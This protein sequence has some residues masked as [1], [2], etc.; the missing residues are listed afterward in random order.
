MAAAIKW[1]IGPSDN[2][3][4]P[5]RSVRTVSFTPAGPP[6]PPGCYF[7]TPPRVP[8]ARACYL[9]HLQASQ[10]Y[11]YT[12]RTDLAKE[13]G[14]PGAPVIEARV[15]QHIEIVNEQQ[16]VK[17]MGNFP[18]LLTSSLS[19]MT[20]TGLAGFEGMLVPSRVTIVRQS[21]G[22]I[23]VDNPDREQACA[24]G[25]VP[26]KKL[27]NR[28]CGRRVLPRVAVV[29]GYDGPGR[30]KT[31]IDGTMS[32]YRHCELNDE[33]GPGQPVDWQTTYQSVATGTRPSSALTRRLFY[34]TPVGKSF[35]SRGGYDDPATP[36][37]APHKRGNVTLSFKR[38]S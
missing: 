29:L 30:F 11:V 12:I 24:G 18:S 31:L 35:S 4:S 14:C 16:P 23:L 38:L 36:G 17:V 37:F 34:G 8:P 9:L 20:A 25:P 26:A 6:R 22:A 2:P 7:P 21:S 27:D 33:A 13:L 10:D 3:Q 19:R 1:R 28:D 15:S 5:T 32:P